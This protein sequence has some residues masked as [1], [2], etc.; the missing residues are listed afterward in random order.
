MHK[1]QLPKIAESI[2]SPTFTVQLS[3]A[4]KRKNELKRRK[5]AIAA[6]DDKNWHE[7]HTYRLFRLLFHGVIDP[8]TPT[9]QRVEPRYALVL[10]LILSTI[11]SVSKKR[12]IIFIWP[13]LAEF[14][15]RISCHAFFKTQAFIILLSL[16][17]FNTSLFVILLF[18]FS[19]WLFF[20]FLILL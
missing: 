2:C 4:R 5:I 11:S 15:V 17:Y 10:L 7:R 12:K 13:A 16:Q 8:H 6:R 14:L 9:F 18:S 1:Y 19:L 3:S 20:S